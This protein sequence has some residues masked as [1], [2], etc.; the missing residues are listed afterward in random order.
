MTDAGFNLTREDPGQMA[1]IEAWGHRR[2][3]VLQAGLDAVLALMLGEAGPPGAADGSVVPLR[4]E[5]DAV[6]DLFGDL[7]D[8][9]V[10]QIDVHGPVHAAAL[11][12]VLTRDREGFV[13][14]GYLTLRE[15]AAPLI[16]FERL[17]NVE[18]LVETADEIRLRFT[19]RPAG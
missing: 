11:D 1:I 17:G 16:V 9:L 8:D 10:A 6:A 4:G 2:Q 12:G 7:L 3:D 19:M 13:A 15:D 5:G 18:A 14:W